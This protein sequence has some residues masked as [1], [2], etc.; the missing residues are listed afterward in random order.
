MSDPSDDPND[1]KR[2]EPRVRDLLRT[3]D[4][5]ELQPVTRAQ[6]EA[7][8]GLPSYQEVDEQQAAGHRA[9]QQHDTVDTV[10]ER[11]Q[12][13]L[14]R[15]DAA[16]LA[17]AERNVEAA[18]RMRV[19]T[20]PDRPWLTDAPLLSFDESAV[21][22]IP[23]PDEWRE[24]EIP[25]E[26]R[27]K[28]KICTPQASLRDLHR[29]EKE[30][31]VQLQSPWDD[32]GEPPPADPWEPIRSSIRRDYRVGTTV[33]PSPRAVQE[34]LRDLRRVMALPW[35]EARRDKAKQREAELLAAEGPGHGDGKGA[36]G[37][38]VVRGPEGTS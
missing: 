3:A 9:P 16:A 20:V 31:Y 29:P 36:E 24:L 13:A 27:D 23:G 5:P 10:L 6:L 25:Y 12:A 37:V 19:H 2:D 35:H 4:S 14:A 32:M 30:W 15:V 26:L 1:P 38:A 18:L 22:A 33:T 28:M 7:W 21:A 17:T 34:S 11:R 8:F